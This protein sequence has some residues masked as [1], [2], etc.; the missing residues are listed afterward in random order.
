MAVSAVAA[1]SVEMFLNEAMS[2]ASCTRLVDISLASARVWPMD[3]PISPKVEAMSS[4]VPCARPMDS[5]LPSDQSMTVSDCSLNTSP[6]LL[7]VSL[8]SLAPLTLAV[9]A[10]TIGAVTLRVMLPPIS[11]S[12]LDTSWM[13]VPARL[14]AL[15][16]LWAALSAAFLT[17]LSDALAACCA[18][19]A[20]PSTALRMPSTPLMAAL[21]SASMFTRS[22]ARSRLATAATSHHAP[23]FLQRLFVQSRLFQPLAVVQILPPLLGLRKA[24]YVPVLVKKQ[25][26]IARQVQRRVYI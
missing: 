14:D 13:D 23:E 21:L 18:S 19:S 16:T 3:V 7:T 12:F 8:R 5:M 4:A 20:T 22:V 26:E 17:A 15:S 9:K 6:V 2:A 1:R 11:V 24:V 25:I 10:A